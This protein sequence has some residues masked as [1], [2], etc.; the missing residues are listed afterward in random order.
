MI[1]AL[2]SGLDIVKALQPFLDDFKQPLQFV[3]VAN[4]PSCGAKHEHRVPRNAVDCHI[5][6]RFGAAVHLAQVREDHS[7][8]FFA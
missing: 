7:C 6:T 8:Q 2:L 4:R 3:A 1:G 5:D